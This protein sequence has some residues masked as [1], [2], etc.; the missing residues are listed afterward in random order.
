LELVAERRFEPRPQRGDVHAHGCSSAQS[1]TLYVSTL[2][3]RGE[4]GDAVGASPRRQVEDR[5]ETQDRYHRERN[6]TPGVPNDPSNI[7][8]AARPRATSPEASRT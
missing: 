4:A 7:F 2:A 5:T 6:A 8:R 3:P 1:R